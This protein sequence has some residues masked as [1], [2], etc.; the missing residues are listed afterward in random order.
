MTEKRVRNCLWQK[1]I[2]SRVENGKSSS[3]SDMYG[4]S[5]GFSEEEVFA[6]LDEYDMTDW[7]ANIR[8]I[9]LEV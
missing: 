4:N 6:A 1:S 5:F 3:T 7:M 9:F 8:S 2:V